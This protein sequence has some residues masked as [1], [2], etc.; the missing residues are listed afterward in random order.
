M[1]VSFSFANAKIIFYAEISG[2][3]KEFRRLDIS[4]LSSNFNEVF[5]VVKDQAILLDDPLC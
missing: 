3:W 4:S 5:N 2:A 1:L